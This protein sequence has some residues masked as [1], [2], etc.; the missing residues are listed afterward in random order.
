MFGTNLWSFAVNRLDKIK[1]ALKKIHNANFAN[2]V[3]AKD[4]FD[5][6]L[7]YYFFDL[8]GKDFTWYRN[9]KSHDIIAADFHSDYDEIAELFNELSHAYHGFFDIEFDGAKKIVFH[10]NGGIELQ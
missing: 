2:Y 8:K 7:R 10:K 4:V 1:A 6:I 3:E 5:K 9:L